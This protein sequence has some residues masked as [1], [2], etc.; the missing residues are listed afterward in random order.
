[1]YSGTSPEPAPPPP[2]PAWNGNEY[3]VSFDGAGSYMK[4][5]NNFAT[6]FRSSF[7]VSFWIKFN[8]TSGTQI[9]LS[10]SNATAFDRI[11]FWHDGT[12]LNAFYEANDVSTGLLGS[13]S[14]TWTNWNHIVA[15]FEQSGSSCV[16]VLYVNGSS[17][18][19]KSTTLDM[20]AYGT[21]GAP[22]DF[23]VWA[24]RALATSIGFYSNVKLDEMAFFGS[25]LSASDVSTIYSSGVPADISSFSPAHWWRMGDNDGGSGDTITDKGQ[26]SDGV[27][28]VL[29]NSPTFSTTVPS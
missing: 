7:S 5:D 12:V 2:P 9:L 19:N 4:C 18:A 27:D 11:Q 6:L 14:Q 26:G 25:A 21:V 23:L 13:G 1:M 8:D 17:V 22:P 15:T 28:G 20:S 29:I 10:S 24:A 16:S 3:T